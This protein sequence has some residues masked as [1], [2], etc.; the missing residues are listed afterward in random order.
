VELCDEPYQETQKGEDDKARKVWIFPVCF[1]LDSPPIEASVLER[2]EEAKR[3]KAQ[4]LTAEQ[5]K[6]KAKD[7]QNI[8]PCS[9]TVRTN[10]YVRNPYVSE[11]AKRLANGR[12]QLCGAEAPFMDKKNK[13]YLETHHIEWLSE[14]GA[15]TIENTV[16]LCPNCH[17]RMHV[18]NL[19]EDITKLISAHLE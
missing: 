6:N 15:D 14:G 2:L 16:A 3:R 5:L 17:R 11:Y 13:P 9:R 8:Q 18:L 4:R 7:N 10:T 19:V 12:C 1:K